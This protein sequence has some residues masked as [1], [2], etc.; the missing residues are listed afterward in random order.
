MALQM[1]APESRQR[2]A[3]TRDFNRRL[4]EENVIALRREGLVP[5]A[6]ADRLGIGFGRVRKI[7]QAHGLEPLGFVSSEPAGPR[8]ACP[9]CGAKVR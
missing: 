5:V 4:D 3:E 1:H 8:T 9:K 7:L 6:I 2:A